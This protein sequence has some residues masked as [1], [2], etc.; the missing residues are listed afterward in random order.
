MC[1]RRTRLAVPLTGGL[2][3]LAAFVMAPDVGAA[4]QAGPGCT[5]RAAVA[6]DGLGHR[7]REA[8]RG[9]V[10]C[11][12]QTGYQTSETR[13]GIANDGTVVQ[14]PA[15]LPQEPGANVAG[16][17][18]SGFAS[19]RN[20][21]ATWQVH[22]VK[23]AAT[24]SAH[25]SW[26]SQ[27]VNFFVD[28]ATGRIFA[29]AP[30]LLE[31]QPNLAY[32]D[33]GGTT[34]VTSRPPLGYSVENPNFLFAKP[35]TSKTSGYPN[36]VYY[37]ENLT[38][39][40]TSARFCSKS[41]DGGNSWNTIPEQGFTGTAAGAHPE[42]GGSREEFSPGGEGY[43][44]AQPDGSL[45]LIVS[46]GGKHFMARSVD[47]AQTWPIVKAKN[48]QPLVVRH[49]AGRVAPIMRADSAGNL[50]VIS[51]IGDKLL[52]STSRDGGHTWSREHNLVPPGVRAGIWYMQARE[53]GHVAVS[54]YAPRGEGTMVDAWLSETRNALSGKPVFWS[55]MVNNPARPALW[56]SR[57]NAPWPLLDFVGVDIAPDGTVWGSFI[58]DCGPNP[59]DGIACKGRPTYNNVGLV[60]S[61]RWDSVTG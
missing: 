34:W 26:T 18:A 6:H 59:G 39:F 7:L 44:V 42:C 14:Y 53:P 46:C 28:R 20:G 4:P 10:A 12:V 56:A 47:E 32:S 24:G 35:R 57:G 58:Q 1:R 9:P 27:D 25:P 33:D 51:Q 43:P 15:L 49:L 8:G 61:L 31:V 45:T 2:V 30:E 11:A 13:I 50:Y 23:L 29:S 60:G 22:Q 21:G 52:L 54:F 38:P 37:C 16:K 41:L 36:V 48:G 17:A 3:L 19:S 40:G 5:S 55:A